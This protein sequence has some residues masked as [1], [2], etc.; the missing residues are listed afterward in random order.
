MSP[1]IVIEYQDQVGKWQRY[2]EIHNE[3]EASQVAK[4][5]AKSTKKRHRLVDNCGRLLDIVEP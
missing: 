3:A 4:Q 5:R 2:K 1:V